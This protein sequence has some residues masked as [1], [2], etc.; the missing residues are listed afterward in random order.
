MT[1][2]REIEAYEP[3]RPELETEHLGKWA[4]VHD[5]QLIGVY[6]EFEEAADA[7]CQ[8]FGKGP[9]LIKQIGDPP[10]IP[11]SSMLYGRI[12]G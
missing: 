3:L 4:L 2:L 8:K 1:L 12:H 7:A 10:V 9:Y 6:S 5:G 11:P